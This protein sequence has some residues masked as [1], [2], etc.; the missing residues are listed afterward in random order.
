MVAEPADRRSFDSASRD[1]AA[2]S[3]AQDDTSRYF[4]GG[5]LTYKRNA[6][7]LAACGYLFTSP[8]LFLKVFVFLDG[9]LN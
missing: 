7:E 3:Y 2:R 4:L 1:K 8:Y 5:E 9:S 6:H